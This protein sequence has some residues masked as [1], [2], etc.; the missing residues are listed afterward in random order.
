MRGRQEGKGGLEETTASQLSRHT[1]GILLPIF[2]AILIV[3]WIQELQQATVCQLMSLTQTEHFVNP[4]EVENTEGWEGWCLH[5]PSLLLFLIGFPYQK[6]QTFHN[7]RGKKR[8]GRKAGPLQERQPL[9]H[10]TEFTR[11]KQLM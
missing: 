10:F 9:F 8:A 4:V 5:A 7:K 3:S 11:K 1:S 2:T 6:E